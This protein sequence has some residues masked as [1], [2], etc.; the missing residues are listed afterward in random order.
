MRY[1]ITGG[2]GFIGSNYVEHLFENVSNVTGVTIFDKLTY[3]ANKKNL[4]K[5]EHDPRFTMIKGDICNSKQ[6]TESMVNHDF[7]INFAAESHVDKSIKS[8][9]SFIDT[10]FVGTFNVLEASLANSIK[11]VIQVSTDEVYGSIMNSLANEEFNLQP[12]SPYSASKAS[13]DLLARSYFNTFGLDVRVT[14]SCNNYGKYQFPEK[15]IPYFIKVLK[16]NKKVPIY[17][18]GKNIRE[19][20]H[21]SDNCKAIQIALNCGSAGEIYNIGGG[22]RISNNELATRLIAIMH[23]PV[24]SFE[25]VNDRPGHDFRYALDCSKIENLGFKTEFDFTNGLEN[26]INWYLENPNWFTK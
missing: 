4:R 2:A 17:G 20:I 23:K 14:R 10:N 21:V 11:T 19:W 24:E 16:N 15:I 18:D 1:F 6:L 5:Y 3:A 26:T 22:I 25:Y 9:S 13:A 7:V 8:P 12:N